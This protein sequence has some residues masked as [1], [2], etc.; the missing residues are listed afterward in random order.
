MENTEL[1]NKKI[2]V[3]WGGPVETGSIFILHSNEYESKTTKKFKELSI[4][5]D[6]KTLID[7]VKN[8]GPVYAIVPKL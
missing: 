7:I 8:Q 1:N 6:H 2:K 4:S 5:R 3:F